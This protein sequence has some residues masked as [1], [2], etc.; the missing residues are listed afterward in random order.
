MID[1][2]FYCIKI[3]YYRVITSVKSITW[4]DGYYDNGGTWASCNSSWLT[5]SDATSCLTW[6]DM[7]LNSTTKLCQRCPS[8][9]YFDTPRQTWQSWG[10]SWIDKWAY[11]SFWFQWG[12]SQYFDLSAMKCVTAW[13]STT[14]ISFNDTQFQNIPVCRGTSYYVNPNSTQIVELGTKQYPYK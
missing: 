10:S 1:T 2:K 6:S 9:Q 3:I 12:S 11:Q 14:Q 7:F 5:W 4:N 8:G 13:N